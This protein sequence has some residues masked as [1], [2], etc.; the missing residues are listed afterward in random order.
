M[1]G[2]VKCVC[3]GGALKHGANIWNFD[4]QLLILKG[5]KIRLTDN[6]A[7]LFNV[8]FERFGGV[9]GL[10]ILAGYV[11]GNNSKTTDDVGSMKYTIKQINRKIEPFGW[12]IAAIKGRGVYLSAFSWGEGWVYDL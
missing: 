8:L 11:Y 1:M 7:R 2:D 5:C 9:F 3:C 12:R 10:E 6:Q 4:A